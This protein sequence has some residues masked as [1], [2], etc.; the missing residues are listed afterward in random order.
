AVE[1]AKVA[2]ASGSTAHAAQWWRRAAEA[3]RE[4]GQHLA[5]IPLLQSA[6]EWEREPAT[7]RELHYL[8]AT[9]T[10]RSG[11]LRGTVQRAEQELSEFPDAPRLLATRAVARVWLDDE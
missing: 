3:R 4:Q 1:A 9:S 10:L 5:A 8:I 11:D 2:H 7:R 6:L